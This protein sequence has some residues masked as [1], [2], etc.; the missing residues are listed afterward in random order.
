M[1]TENYFEWDDSLKLNVPSM[2]REHQILIDLMNKLF[3]ANKKKAPRQ[4]RS[5]ILNEL[6]D[7]SHKHFE[8][9]ERY[10]QSIKFEGYA[11]HKITHDRLLA[12]LDAF[13]K[14][15]QTNPIDD[16]PK[17]LFIFLK[18]WIKSHIKGIDVKYSDAS[19]HAGAA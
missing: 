3:I 4:M 18:V 16:L 8:D 17:E 2:N 7:Y 9:E 19:V 6:V 14:D 13:L 11:T 12:K 1:T 5:A 10:M 15:Y